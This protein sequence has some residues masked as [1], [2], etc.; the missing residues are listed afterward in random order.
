[1]TTYPANDLAALKRAVEV[2]R[3][4]GLVAYPTDTVYGLAA[5]PANPQAVEKLFEAKRRPPNQPVPLLL[6]SAADVALVVSDVPEVARRLMDAFWPGALTIVLRKAPSFQSAAV[7]ETVG[8][9][10]PDHPVPRELARLL[11]GP[12]TGTSSNVSGGPEPLTA[13]E[14]RSQLGDAVDLI[15]DGDRCPGGRPSTVV[16][17]TVEPPRIVREGAIS[18]QELERATRTKFL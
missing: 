2:L 18:R 6:A 16:D 1:M 15:L 12:I 13:D 3:R 5:D 14:A 9:R 4:G 10:V 11:G 7:G 8:L 17:C